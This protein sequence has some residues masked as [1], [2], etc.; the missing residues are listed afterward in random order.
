MTKQ[1]FDE[2]IKNV[3]ESKKELATNW[4]IAIGLQ[5][6][7]QLNV[8]EYLL[9]L[10]KRNI[11][12]EISIAEVKKLVDEYHAKRCPPGKRRYHSTYTRIPDKK[13]K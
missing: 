4:A 11:E 2:Y 5:Q 1:E 6:V 10:A 12:G 9:E 8:S 3:D 13:V 7:D